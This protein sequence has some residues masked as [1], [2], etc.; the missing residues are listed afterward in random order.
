MPRPTIL[1]ADDHE[2]LR[3]HVRGFL[4]ADFDVVAAV[5]DGGAAVE[6]AT[7]LRPDVVL[8]DITMPVLN[9]L[10]A[11]ARLA[12]LGVSSRV[13]FLTVHDDEAFVSAARNVGACAYVL[14]GQMGTQLLRA[15]R[16]ALTTS[17]QFLPPSAP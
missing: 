2:L 1:I 10:A 8:F 3:G 5:A 9:G 11:A 6:A 4:A 16:H 7:R 13:V 12:E 17:V 14:K 15:I